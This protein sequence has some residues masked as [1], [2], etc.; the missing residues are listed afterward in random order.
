MDNS[1]AR[2]IKQVEREL[3]LP[4]Y[5]RKELLRGL[6]VEL[7][8]R[9]CDS[10]ETSANLNQLGNP[11]EIASMLLESVDSEQRRQYYMSKLLRFRCVAA[12]LAIVLALCVGTLFYLAMTQVVRS[13]V[14]VI[15][16]PIPTQY[17]ANVGSK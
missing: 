14:T 17:F 4:R 10:K 3:D 5:Q 1:Y 9:F 8:E 6:Q 13:D 12:A 16:D 11:K 2:Y 15:Q 7:E